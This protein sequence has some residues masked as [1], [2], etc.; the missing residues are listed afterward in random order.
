M[1][2]FDLY[3]SETGSTLCETSLAMEKSMTQLAHTSISWGQARLTRCLPKECGLRRFWP[4][5][6]F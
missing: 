5:L 2:R 4:M 1:S 6:V 3:R